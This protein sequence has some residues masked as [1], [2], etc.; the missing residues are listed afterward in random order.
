MSD[1]FFGQYAQLEGAASVVA[2]PDALE[3]LVEYYRLAAG[4]H[5]NWEEYRES[6]LTERRVLVRIAVDHAGPTIAG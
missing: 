4:E 5:P 3:G 2:L 6:M 1:G